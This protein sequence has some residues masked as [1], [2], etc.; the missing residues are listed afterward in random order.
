MRLL[1]IA[2]IC[3]FAMAPYDQFAT[4][5]EGELLLR[6]AGSAT[7]VLLCWELVS[8]RCFLMIAG[9]E[10]VAIGYNLAVAL[11]YF[12][13]DNAGAAVYANTMITLFII[14][15]LSVLMS[16]SVADSPRTDRSDSHS[17]ALNR[18]PG[19]HRDRLEK[20]Q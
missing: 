2:F 3:L 15:V 20:P 19:L 7:L 14:Q 11:G 6:S 5:L 4:T 10:A 18:D 16:K 8:S 12:V 17:R 1:A 13:T 9:C